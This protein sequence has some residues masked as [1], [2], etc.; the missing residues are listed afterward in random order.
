MRLDM[1]P[2][3]IKVNIKNDGRSIKNFNDRKDIEA[4]QNIKISNNCI[5]K[6]NKFFFKYTFIDIHK[7]NFY[8]KFYLICFFKIIY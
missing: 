1:K 4:E 6:I 7:I 5:I 2:N 3:I 8:L